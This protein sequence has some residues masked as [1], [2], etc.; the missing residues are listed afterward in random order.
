MRDVYNLRQ[1]ITGRTEKFAL[2]YRGA[3]NVIT[4]TEVD[5]STFFQNLLNNLN[6]LE[7]HTSDN[8]MDY[9]LRFNNST[10]AAGV[11]FF[12][13]ILCFF[14]VHSLPTFSNVKQSTSLIDEISFNIC[15]SFIC[16]G[17]GS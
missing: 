16:L 9:G 8:I 11:Q 10:T 4:T 5:I 1:S 12:K 15:S 14:A 6:S 13:F 7:L 17:K 2:I 3:R